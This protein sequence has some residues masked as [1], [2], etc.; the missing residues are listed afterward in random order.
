MVIKIVNVLPILKNKCILSLVFGRPLREGTS[1]EIPFKPLLK[2]QKLK[3]GSNNAWCWM[4]MRQGET[5]DRKWLGAISTLWQKGWKEELSV[6]KEPSERQNHEEKA[7]G[8]SEFRRSPV[9]ATGLMSKQGRD[10]P[11]PPGH[12]QPSLRLDGSRQ[13]RVKKNLHL[14]LITSL[15]NVLDGFL[16]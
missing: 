11:C 14:L 7:T 6:E 4:W 8:I 1:H 15:R 3:T 2:P 12:T 16:R 13:R 10:T 5:W 9:V